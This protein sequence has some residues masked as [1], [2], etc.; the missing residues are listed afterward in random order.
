[1]YERPEIEDPDE[2]VKNDGLSILGTGTVLN[3][4]SQKTAG[5]PGGFTAVPA[6]Q[7]SALMDFE[8]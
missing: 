3:K 6:S 4:E 7:N 5:N 8:A 2:E 1:L